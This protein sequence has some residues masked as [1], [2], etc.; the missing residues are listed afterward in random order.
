MSINLELPSKA[1]ESEAPIKNVPDQET[2]A[3]IS[4]TLRQIEKLSPDEQVQVENFAKQIDLHDIDIVTRYGEAAQSKLQTFTD[5][6]L[7]GVR[8]NDVGEIGKLLTEM[9]VSIKAFNDETDSKFMGFLRS[10]KRK[11]ESL[12]VRYDDVTETLERIKKDLVGRRMILL[13]DNKMLDTIYNQNLE[14]F[15]ELTMYVLAGKQKLA[16]ARSGE[17]EN[18]RRIASESNDQADAFAYSDFKDHCE[19]FEKQLFDLELTRSVCLQTAPQIRMVQQANVLLARK[20]QSSIN[21]TIPIWK[22]K[23]AIAL[24]IQHT[25][26]A[27][28][29]QKATTDL[30]SQMLE[31]N[32]KQLHFSVTAAAKEAERGVIDIEAL[33][34]SNTELL[35]TIDD[36]ITIQEEGRQKRAAAELELRK[37]EEDLKQKLIGVSQRTN[38]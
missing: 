4:D 26:D 12:R 34:N 22:Q 23:I 36:V 25:E 17:L 11:A 31:D 2:F 10:T 16:E 9:S 7:E 33:K 27:A 30:T 19:S 38:R 37:A 18:L 20:I 29:A 32:A 13:K 14:Y 8:G 6:A 21:N 28:K 5:N 24:A 35:A 1:M 3:E 15:K